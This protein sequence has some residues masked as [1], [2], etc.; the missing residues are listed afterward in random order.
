MNILESE[1]F[2]Y[3]LQEEGWSIGRL[4]ELAIIEMVL[5]AMENDK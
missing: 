5:E 1:R 2:I 4:V 3:M